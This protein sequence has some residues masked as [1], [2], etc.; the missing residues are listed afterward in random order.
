MNREELRARAAHISHPVPA[1]DVLTNWHASVEAGQITWED[2]RAL[3]ASIMPRCGCG[4]SAVAYLGTVA[5]CANCYDETAL[6]VPALLRRGVENIHRHIA[7]LREQV[8][9]LDRNSQA[10][11][12]AD[13]LLR[14]WERQRARHEGVQP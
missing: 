8:A 10:Y 3:Q 6:G 11:A 1:A 2:F 12:R 7:D 4:A 5:V 13:Y 14:Y 9:I